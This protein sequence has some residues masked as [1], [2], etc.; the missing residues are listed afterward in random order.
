MLSGNAFNPFSVWFDFPLS[1]SRNIFFILL[2]LEDPSAKICSSAWG[3]KFH[4][5]V[6]YFHFSSSSLLSSL[7]SASL[8]PTVIT[9]VNRCLPFL[10]T[11]GAD[12]PGLHNNWN[13]TLGRGAP[14]AYTEVNFAIW[15]AKPLPHLHGE[16]DYNH[17][18]Q[19]GG[20]ILGMRRWCQMPNRMVCD[21]WRTRENN[22]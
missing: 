21:H 9:S 22:D 15:T 2:C 18:W 17:I 13:K 16:P 7:I 11:L 3:S 20:S 6:Q 19:C 1:Q 14:A 10:M 5:C 8:S 12:S 4:T